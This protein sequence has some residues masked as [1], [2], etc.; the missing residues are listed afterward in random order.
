MLCRS[1]ADRYNT[2]SLP[3]DKDELDALL[4][5][6]LSSLHDLPEAMAMVPTPLR[7]CMDST[8]ITTALQRPPDLNENALALY[9]AFSL[10]HSQNSGLEP[11]VF[12]V[13]PCST[14]SGFWIC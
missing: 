9:H 14:R 4:P 6:L 13:S 5:E 1:L 12:L 11:Y 7:Q 2:Q 10:E 3:D 8:S